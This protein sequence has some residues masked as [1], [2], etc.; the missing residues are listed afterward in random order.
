MGAATKATRRPA[1]SS[2]IK[3]PR[4]PKRPPPSASAAAKTCG[5]GYRLLLSAEGRIFVPQQAQVG[6]NPRGPALVPYHEIEQAPGVLPREQDNP[7]GNEGHDA[8]RD[9]IEVKE[10]S[11]GDANIEP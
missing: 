7:E 5:A 1:R 3:A 10:Y 6:R 11:V 4:T 2:S 9:G 8:D